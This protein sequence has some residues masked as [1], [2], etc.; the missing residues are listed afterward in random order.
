[1]FKMASIEV[2]KRLEKRATAAEQLIEIIKRHIN[3]VRT[4]ESS[5]GYEIH[6]LKT[7]NNTLRDEIE[8]WK[9]R[10]ITSET[11]KGIRQFPGFTTLMKPSTTGVSS[12]PI[13]NN[14]KVSSD[15]EDKS[16]STVT[17]KQPSVKKETKNKGGEPK[18]SDEPT[19]DV[20]R[21]DIRVGHIISA[22]KHADADSLYVESIDVGEEKPR[23]VISGLVKF[24]PEAEMQDRMVVV[25][26]NLKPSKMRGIMSEAMVMCASTPDKV[27]LLCPPEGTKPGD[28]VHVE[29]YERNPDTQL[30]PK[31]KIFE[32]CAPD[33][34]TNSEGF[35]C[36]KNIPWVVNGKN[37]TSQTLKNVQVK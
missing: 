34:K 17:Q 26:C 6:R 4:S 24:I 12:E 18:K 2:M 30:N 1:M 37:V 31:K 29:G 11:S 22:K 19:V 36:Y 35:A 9:R 16:S 33:L 15:S 23:T 27:E 14:P 8:Q 10:L 20:G 7:E 28:L 13:T 5:Y 32:L 3:E 21:L 25:L